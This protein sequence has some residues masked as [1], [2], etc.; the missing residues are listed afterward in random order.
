ML[1]KETR[2]PALTLVLES[3][4]TSS[5]FVHLTALQIYSEMKNQWLN[6]A[7]LG[8]LYFVLFND[9]PR[10]AVSVSKITQQ[11][12]RSAKSGQEDTEILFKTNIS[13]SPH[14]ATEKGDVQKSLRTS[15]YILHFHE[16]LGI[17][18]KTPQSLVTWSNRPI[19]S[20][21]TPSSVYHTHFYFGNTGCLSP[22]KWQK[23]AIVAHQSLHS[24]P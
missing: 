5:L 23:N 19:T 17:G 6:I 15:R 21:E 20:L 24:N 3:I 22:L 12:V 14:H 11:Q 8:H 9:W 4:Q 13:N 2:H 1:T 10:C 18:L 16:C 7:T